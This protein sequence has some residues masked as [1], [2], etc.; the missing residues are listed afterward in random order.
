MI[1]VI[2]QG[3]KEVTTNEEELKLP[4][5]VRQIGDCACGENGFGNYAPEDIK[6]YVEDFVMTYIKHFNSNNLRYGVLLGNVKKSNGY[7][8]FFVTGTVLANLF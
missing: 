6:I 5:N 8:Y 1:E 2:Y 4:K 3:E 7:T